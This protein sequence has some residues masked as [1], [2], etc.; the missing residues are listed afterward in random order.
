MAERSAF[1]RAYVAWVEADLRYW[2]QLKRDLGLRDAVFVY[3]GSNLHSMTA[4]LLMTECRAAHG[5]MMQIYH[6]AER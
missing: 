5:R 3:G 1:C 4:I 6:S 2:S